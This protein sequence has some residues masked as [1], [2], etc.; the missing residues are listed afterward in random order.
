VAH[1]ARVIWT[2]QDRELMPPDG[3]RHEI[4]YERGGD[5][6]PGAPARSEIFPFSIAVDAV[7][8]DD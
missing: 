5:C 2:Y 8:A 1:S 7:F 3:R 6:G 4:E